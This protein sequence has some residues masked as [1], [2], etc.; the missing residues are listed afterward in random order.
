MASRNKINRVEQLQVCLWLQKRMDD[1]GKYT[2][3]ELTRILKEEIGISVTRNMLGMC[4]TTIGFKRVRGGTPGS[5]KDRT[6]VVAT[7]LVKVLESLGMPVTDQLRDIRDG[8]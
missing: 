4:E 1:L 5:M 2:R 3:T 7:E 6:R 8:V